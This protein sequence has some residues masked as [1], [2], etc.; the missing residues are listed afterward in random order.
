MWRISS[1]LMDNANVVRSVTRRAR[2]YRRDRCRQV[3]S[4]RVETARVL[5]HLAR[6]RIPLFSQFGPDE[7]IVNEGTRIARTQNP[8]GAFETAILQSSSF[9]LFFF[10]FPNVLDI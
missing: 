5:T 3:A 8:S 6:L 1:V 9:S 4:K 7:K 10:L 2:V